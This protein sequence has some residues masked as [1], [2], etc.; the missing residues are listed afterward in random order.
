MKELYRLTD[1]TYTDDINIYC[2]NW[3]DLGNKVIENLPDLKSLEV[4]SY[5]P[6]IQFYYKTTSN[7]SKSFTLDTEI[8]KA[9]AKLKKG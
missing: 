7:Y 2:D 8:C 4:L 5:D 1:N 6:N 9:I 3:R